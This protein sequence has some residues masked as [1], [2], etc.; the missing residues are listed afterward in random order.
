M[1][2]QPGSTERSF[3]VHLGRNIFQCFHADCVLKGNVL[4]FWAAVHRLP[5]YEAA[6]NL[7][8]TFQLCPEQ[9]RGTRQ[10]NHF[11]PA[12]DGEPDRLGG[13]GTKQ[14][15]RVVNKLADSNI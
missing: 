2:S 9:R 10:R 4:D 12:A 7:A 15:A 11:S 14:E 6:F 1:H 8:E 13:S 5:L 3:S